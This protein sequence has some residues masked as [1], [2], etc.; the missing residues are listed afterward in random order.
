[1][2]DVTIECGFRVCTKCVFNWVETN[3]N[4]ST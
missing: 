2:S 4:F 3:V 1:M